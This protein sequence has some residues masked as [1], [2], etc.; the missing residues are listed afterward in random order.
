[1]GEIS[2]R[3]TFSSVDPLHKLSV[4]TPKYDVFS[5]LQFFKYFD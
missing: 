1:M 5:K 2:P 4:F 3:M